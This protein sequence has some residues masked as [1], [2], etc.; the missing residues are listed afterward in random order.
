MLPNIS[1]LADGCETVPT[2]GRSKARSG[3]GTNFYGNSSSYWK[4][5]SSRK[6][7]IVKD[8]MNKPS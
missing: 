7:E 3:H 6:S 4:A 2:D 1:S 8:R 5:T